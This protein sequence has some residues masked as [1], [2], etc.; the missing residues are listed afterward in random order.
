MTETLAKWRTARAAHCCIFC[1]ETIKP[2][3]RYVRLTT[4]PGNYMLQNPGWL[5]GAAH[6]ETAS[7]CEAYWRVDALGTAYSSA[8]HECRG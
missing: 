3:E 7:G 2:G 8:A 1:G 4:P 6:G 5:S